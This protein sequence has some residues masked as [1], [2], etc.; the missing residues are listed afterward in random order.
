[1]TTPAPP[2]VL[3]V[4]HHL[5]MGGME[6]GLLNLINRM[7]PARYRHAIAC[8]EDYS[9]FRERL[10]QP[11]VE[12]YPLYRSQ[13]GVWGLRRALFELCK[14]IRPTIVHSRNQSGL[15]A[16]LPAALAGVPYR[17][18]GEHGWDMDDIGGT[19]R[20]PALLRRL[21]APF[22]NR[23]ITV[24]KDLE[25]Y[26]SNRIGVRAERI[27]QIYNGVDVARFTPLTPKSRAWLPASFQP[28]DLL[29]IGSVGRAQ[30]VKDQ[31]TLIQAFA[32]LINAH[33]ALRATLRLTIV[34]DGPMLATLRAQVTTLGLNELI[35]LPGALNAIPE[36]LS[37]LDVFVLPSLNEGISNT[38]LEA[39]A[40]GL[41]V[42]AT[43]VGGNLE[44]IEGG[45]TGAFFAPRDTAALSRLLHPSATDPG[46][47]HRHGDAGR[48]IA[49]SR[50]SLNAMVAQYID[51]YDA[52][53]R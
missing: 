8:V 24:S 42:I 46:L 45:R 31:A 39:M 4:I 19:R 50:F 48:Q 16:L 38:L 3:H 29:L 25:K 47:R 53:C 5:H 49:V 2:L 15:D 40:A 7:P 32:D 52:L 17:V 1:M 11:A 33:S 37:S 22:V 43:A 6:N 36:V 44:L 18:H 12:I 23:Y 20:K 26:L 14:Q 21:H 13:R 10:T 9:D 34:G 35:Y 51:V 30:E 27:T 41:P 28:E